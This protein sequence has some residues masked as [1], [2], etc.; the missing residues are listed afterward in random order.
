MKVARVF[1]RRTKAS[2]DDELAF[3]GPPGLFPPEVDQ[4]E[5][6]VAFTWDLPAA[7]RL[8]A[9]WSRVAPVGIGGPALGWPSGDFE[10][11]RYL[12]PGYTITS[13]GCPN[14]CPFCDAWRREGGLR[15]LEIKDGWIVQDDNLLACSTT[16]VDAVFAMLRRQKHES[17][18]RG[19]EARLLTARHVDLL[20]SLRVGAAIFACDLPDDLDPLITAARLLRS[21]GLIRGHVSHEFRAYVL[22]GY[23]N[24]TPAA[25]ELRLLQVLRLGLL[26]FAMLYR[27]HAGKVASPAAVWQKLRREWIRPHIIMTKAK[28]LKP[29]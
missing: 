6:S 21:S 15:E 2:P 9:E 8:A 22:I 23:A 5:I 13:R 29:L 26:P 24:D 10:P 18:L 25:A 11:G 19:L 28:G 17:Q 1:P 4:A 27:D 20:L 16:H 7:E 3:F 14:R 12:R